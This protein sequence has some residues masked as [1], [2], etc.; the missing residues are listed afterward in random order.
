MI[1]FERK[2]EIAGFC[3]ICKLP[4][5]ESQIAEILLLA[6]SEEDGGKK[7]ICTGC[8]KRSKK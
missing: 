3:W 7:I 6:F 8:S 4:V 2:R 5:E 1:F